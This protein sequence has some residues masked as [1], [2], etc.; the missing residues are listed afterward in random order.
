[1]ATDARLGGEGEAEV[2][3]APGAGA[4]GL[5]DQ[6]RG[7]RMA[8][9]GSLLDMMRPAVQADGGD[10]V[11][12][13]A[14]VVSGVVEVQLQGSCS[15]CAIS[16]TTLQAGVERILRDRLSWVTEVRGGL[17]ESIA[18]DDSLSLGRGGYIP[19]L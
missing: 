12:L 16:S 18:F 14:D 9:L 13:H 1:M 15:S 8:A 17:D 11:L 5:S 2:A 4:G 6:E 7:E 3:P 10:L 19:R